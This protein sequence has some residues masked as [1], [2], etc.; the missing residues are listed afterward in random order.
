MTLSV[1]GGLVLRE[2]WAAHDSMPEQLEALPQQKNF[3][4]G[5]SP[6]QKTFIANVASSSLGLFL[7]QAGRQ[8]SYRLRDKLLPP[9]KVTLAST[10]PTSTPKLRIR[11]SDTLDLTLLLLVRA[12]DSILQ[13]YIQRTAPQKN[14]TRV[15]QE[16]VAEAATILTSRIDGFIFW[17][18]SA[19]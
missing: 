9:A 18:C 10:P 11:T 16:N 8:R 4:A 13:D 12:A 5:L 14:G 2:L 1:G 7:L 3:F 19:R 17:A 6:S 15:S